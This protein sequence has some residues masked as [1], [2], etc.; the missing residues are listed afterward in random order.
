MY[1]EE[2]SFKI[3]TNFD[4]KQ[5]GDLGSNLNTSMNQSNVLNSIARDE[6]LIEGMRRLVKEYL[7]IVNYFH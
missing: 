1:T 7:E 4:R 2:M 5:M 3:Q 6:K